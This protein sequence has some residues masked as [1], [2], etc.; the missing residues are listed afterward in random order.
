MHYDGVL[1]VSLYYTG[2][3]PR[4]TVIL[5]HGADAETREM[6]WIVPYYVC[7][8]V[9]VIS[10][11]QRG[12]GKSSGNWRAS[13]PP[14]R[15]RDVD[16]IYDAFRND[17]HVDPQR[18]G[19]WGF[20]NGGW[21]API[22]AVDRPM[23]FMILK[24]PPA[25]SIEQNSLFE[26]RQALIQTGHSGAD[27]AR[28]TAAL[29]TVLDA[30]LGKAPI[31]S[32]KA[33]Y[34]Q[35]RRA[36]WYKDSFLAMVGEKDA[37]TEPHLSGWRRYLGYDPAPVLAEVRTPTLALF[38]ARDRRVDVKNDAPAL[39]TAYAK[40]G[41]PLTVKW[42]SDAGHTLKVSPNGFEAAKPERYS[43]GFP[44]VM[45]DWLREHNFVR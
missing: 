5:I 31:S 38:G 45:L 9:N 26:Q 34:A 1:G 33:A 3:E 37:L 44:E 11:D 28:A 39:T 40:S 25:G 14:D 42:F 13:G 29:K 36:K 43:R 23:A 20:S 16:A 21:T 17:A 15:A 24:S 30:I 6:G 8:G 10:Y 27:I 35:A 19:V 7:N 22:V 2:N 4:T 41:T 18:I 32:A 12:T